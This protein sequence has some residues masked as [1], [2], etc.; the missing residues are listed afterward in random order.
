MQEDERYITRSEIR[1]LLDC[2]ARWDFRYSDRLAGSS[3][4]PIVVPNLLALGTSWDTVVKT[5]NH[6][7]SVGAVLLDLYKG[8]DNRI[9]HLAHRYASLYKPMR[10]VTVKP[11]IVEILPGMK[12]AI[13][14]DDRLIDENGRTW[15][16]EYKLRTSLTSLE[17][18]QRDLQG[19]LYVYGARKSGKEVAGVIFDEMLNE[20]PTEMRFKKDGGPSK[21]QSCSV[22]EYIRGCEAIGFDPDPDIV[23]KLEVR[24]VHQRVPIEFYDFDLEGIDDL[25]KSAELH[26]QLL[27][28]GAMY[29]KR[30]RNPMMCRLCEFNP[31][32]EHPD[33]DLIDFTFTR[34]EARRNRVADPSGH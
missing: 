21:V 33:P 3:L 7:G 14:P 9:V 10:T 18:L 22:Q 26:I 25:L 11:F 23:A 13:Q 28:R 32:C 8:E 16:V 27:E 30:I 12:V 29:P 34:R 15:L 2:E 19:M 20:L 24:R 31:I 17:Y 6:G 4:E 5:Y 1:S